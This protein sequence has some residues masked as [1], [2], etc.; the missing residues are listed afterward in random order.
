MHRIFFTWL[1]FLLLG[2]GLAQAQGIRAT[3]EMASDLH[4]AC[5]MGLMESA[6]EAEGRAIRVQ[7]LR[8]RNYL[9]GFVSATAVSRTGG[10]M[11]SPYSPTGEAL[12]CYQL[13]V[14]MSWDEMEQLV[15]D[16][17]NETPDALNMYAADFLVEVFA[18]HYPCDEPGSIEEN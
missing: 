12:F 15:V 13:P 16:Y 17:G 6:D 3:I 9:S 10:G 4:A 8:C 5:A 14:E 11:T 7:R 2:G 1:V 18:S